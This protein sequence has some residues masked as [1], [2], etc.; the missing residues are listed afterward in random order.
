VV[1]R[2]PPLLVQYQ[3]NLFPGD[4]IVIDIEKMTAKQMVKMYYISSKE[5][6]SLFSLVRTLLFREYRDLSRRL[7]EIYV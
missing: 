4:E 5:A 3:S 1:N 6:F 7:G 2:R